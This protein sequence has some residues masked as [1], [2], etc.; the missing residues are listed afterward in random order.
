MLHV[1]L[2]LLDPIEDMK[3]VDDEF[4]KTVKR[5][6]TLE[7]SLKA[8][9]MSK[10]PEID[11]LYALCQRKTEVSDLVFHAYYTCNAKLCCAI[12]NQTR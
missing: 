3:I 5:I 6:E 10:D 4:A 1:G 7:L 8:H 9:D 11:T 2:P 12:F